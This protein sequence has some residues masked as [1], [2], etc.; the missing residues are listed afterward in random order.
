VWGEER[1]ELGVVVDEAEP[2]SD[3]HIDV[4]AWERSTGNPLGFFRDYIGGVWRGG[5]VT[6]ADSFLWTRCYQGRECSA[7]VELP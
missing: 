6:W 3:L 4:P 5:V 1:R 7:I 2:V